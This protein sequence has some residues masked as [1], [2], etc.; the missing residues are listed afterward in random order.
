[1]SPRCFELFVVHTFVSP[2]GDLGTALRLV[3]QNRAAQGQRVRYDGENLIKSFIHIL[4]LQ[5]QLRNP[6]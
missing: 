4:T 3:D 6:V 1:M 2:N 5:Q